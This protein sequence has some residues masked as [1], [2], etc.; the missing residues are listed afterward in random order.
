MLRNINMLNSPSAIFMVNLA[1]SDLLLIFSLPMRVY[2]YIRGTWF[3]GNMACIWVTML[4]RN[5]IRSSSIFITFISMDRLLAVVYPL[6]SRHLRTSSK[7][8]KGAALVWLIVLALKPAV[9]ESLLKYCALHCTVTRTERPAAAAAA[10]DSGEGSSKQ[11]TLPEAAPRDDTGT[12]GSVIGADGG[13]SGS[14]I[15]ADGDSGSVARADGGESAVS[16]SVVGADGAVSELVVGADG[17]VG[18]EEAVVR[19]GQR[20]DDLGRPEQAAEGAAGRDVELLQVS[21]DSEPDDSV[22]SVINAWQTLK[23]SRTPDPGPGMWVYEEPLFNNDF[24]RNA[25]LSSVTLRTKFVEAGM[26]KLGHLR[27]RE[28]ERESERELKRHLQ[29]LKAIAEFPVAY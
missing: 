8:W 22:N 26:T 2:Y 14:V 27:E 18:E 16:G 11:R 9:S 29:R 1:I 20:V 19:T 28:R 5:N 7:A 15:G 6:R 12:D 17:N 24:L 13:D 25:T 10:V 4:F 21:P 3:F 23:V